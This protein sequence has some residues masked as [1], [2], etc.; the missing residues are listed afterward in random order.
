MFHNQLRFVDYSVRNGSHNSAE[1]ET[2]YYQHFTLFTI[3]GQHF[4]DQVHV[5]WQ[6]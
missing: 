5:I 4:H 1:T 3:S 2:N 6:T